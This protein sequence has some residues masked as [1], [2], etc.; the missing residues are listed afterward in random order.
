MWSVEAMRIKTVTSPN[1][2]CSAPGHTS[3]V[4]T[5]GDGH[6]Q[7]AEGFFAEKYLTAF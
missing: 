1:V 7:A 4:A 2:E 3:N 6:P 5:P